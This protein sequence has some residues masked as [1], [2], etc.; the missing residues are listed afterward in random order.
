MAIQ[1]ILTFREGTLLVPAEVK[2]HFHLAE[3]AR[4]RLTLISDCKATLEAENAAEPAKRRWRSF[5]GL[6]KNKSSQGTSEI[7]SAE[8]AW[9]LAHDER[10]YGFTGK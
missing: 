9:E 3:G 1:A 5:R 4:L 7:L 6:L 8:R 2:E 10:K